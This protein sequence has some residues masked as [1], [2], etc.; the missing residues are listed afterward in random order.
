[1]KHVIRG[2]SDRTLERNKHVPLLFLRIV[3]EEYVGDIISGNFRFTSI[4]KYR[5]IEEIENNSVVGDNKEGIFVSYIENIILKPKKVG[6]PELFI[7]KGIVE[8]EDD[9]T[10]FGI[11]SFIYLKDIDFIYDHA[12]N[13]F[14]ISK[15]ALDDI[16]KLFKEKEEIT[17]KK[18]TCVV[19]NPVIFLSSIEKL[20]GIDGKEIEYY[21][22][23]QV[24]S[25]STNI[26]KKRKKYEYQR[27]YRFAKKLANNVEVETITLDNM[28]DTIVSV[29]IDE[30]SEWIA[31]I[32]THD[33]I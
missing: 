19:I 30:L 22:D 2:D 1:M 27:E 5:K 13:G 7:K 11:L 15:K 6:A 9:I 31:V 3:E 29:T 32:N 21:C 23:N 20:G 24:C 33:K 10:G 17:G 26:F 4:N 18:C 12:Y 16:K 8:F 14:T 28:K 25:N